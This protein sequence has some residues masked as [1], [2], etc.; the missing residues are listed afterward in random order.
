MATLL[1]PLLVRP[2]LASDDLD[3]KDRM[4]GQYDGDRV[5]SDVD[6]GQW[7]KKNFRDDCSRALTVA[8]A[9]SPLAALHI[10][11]DDDHSRTGTWLVYKPL[12]NP[13]SCGNLSDGS[14]YLYRF[15]DGRLI[16]MAHL[17]DFRHLA[18]MP[19]ISTRDAV[20]QVIPDRNY[21]GPDEAD[22]RAFTAGDYRPVAVAP[23]QSVLYTTPGKGKDK[24]FDTFMLFADPEEGVVGRLSGKLWLRKNSRLALSDHFIPFDKLSA[25]PDGAAIW[26]R[27]AV[28]GDSWRIAGKDAVPPPVQGVAKAEQDAFAALAATPPEKMGEALLAWAEIWRDA[29]GVADGTVPGLNERREQLKQ[30]FVERGKALYD[31]GRYGSVMSLNVLES[32][33][34]LLTAHHRDVDGW[35]NFDFRKSIMFSLKSRLTPIMPHILGIDAKQPLIPEWSPIM[36]TDEKL[37]GVDHAFPESVD[38]WSDFTFIEPITAQSTQQWSITLLG[39]VVAKGSERLEKRVQVEK[40]YYKTGDGDYATNQWRQREP[41]RQKRRAA[42]KA[43]IAELERKSLSVPRVPTGR[44]TQVLSG[45][46]TRATTRQIMPFD[47]VVGQQGDTITTGSYS[48]PV[49]TRVQETEPD[50][51]DPIIKALHQAYADMRDGGDPPPQ[52]SNYETKQVTSNYKRQI[53]EAEIRVRL[54]T[55]SGPVD[56][57]VPVRF[58]RET[59]FYSEWRAQPTTIADRMANPTTLGGGD[60]YRSLVIDVFSERWRRSFGEEAGKFETDAFNDLVFGASVDGGLAARQGR[61]LLE[62]LGVASAAYPYW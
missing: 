51:N 29:T 25:Q 26:G 41:E 30:L 21:Y 60:L 33:M 10:A 27:E 61:K 31:E 11:P 15:V 32:A 58:V 18:T 37:L 47:S 52:V 39:P 12:S 24:R 44:Y 34:N 8:D 28:F 49:Y 36:T 56:K 4:L 48:A 17:Y 53:Q 9:D 5:D 40:R 35:G 43:Q 19:G 55:G 42:A 62:L 3:A 16:A 45:Y 6:I 38:Y 14:A 22:M 57:T 46:E 13:Y 50:P 59:D 54:D 2:A 7:I 23:G 20:Y 1:P